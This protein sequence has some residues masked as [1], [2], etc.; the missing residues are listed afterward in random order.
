MR[1]AVLWQSMPSYMRS[2]LEKLAAHD[3]VEA[4]LVVQD[5]PQGDAPFQAPRSSPYEAIEW[6][7]RP[8]SDVVRA[9]KEFAPTGIFISSWHLSAYRRVSWSLRGVPRILCMDNIYTGTPKQ[10]SGIAARGA[11]IRPFFD[12]AWIPGHRQLDF[13]L[14]LGFAHERVHAGLYTANQDVFAAQ[15]TSVRDRRPGFVFSGRGRQQKRL[16]LL[17]S[18][19][20]EY[21]VL[22][23][24]LGLQPWPL[25]VLGANN[26][27]E[28]AG[29]PGV[30][31][32]GFLQEAEAA[33]LIGAFL[34]LVIPSSH[35]PWGVVVH[36]AA[37]SG[38][39]IIASA[40][41]GS[42]MQ[43]VRPGVNGFVFDTD[44]QPGLVRALLEV[45]QLKT[46]R[47]EAMSEAS[48]LLSLQ[49]SPDLWARQA[50]AMIQSLQERTSA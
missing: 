10:R 29:R 28:T 31:C 1:L 19:Y 38:L 39:M 46:A 34:C 43:L 40:A 5:A 11:M 33:R 47:I 14:R 45:S 7:G 35:E 3:E 13:A 2:C 30:H 8:G 21:R 18:A 49:F 48:R 42:R 27:S 9:V 4:L 50:V 20:A 26:E 36:E 22:V 23:E 15:R 16:A 37:S 24:R 12:A 44:D 41:V 6:S 32:H 17:L 25:H